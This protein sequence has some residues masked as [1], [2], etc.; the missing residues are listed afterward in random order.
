MPLFIY[1]VKYKIFPELRENHLE[2]SGS[3]ISRNKIYFLL[4]SP[5]RNELVN[6]S[7]T[8]LVFIDLELIKVI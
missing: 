3:S 2:R 1:I 4:F 6:E 5:G 8:V 7:V